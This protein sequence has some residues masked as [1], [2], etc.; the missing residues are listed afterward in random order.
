MPRL[1][2]CDLDGTLLGDDDALRTLLDALH[3]P[4]APVLAF[5][6]GRQGYSAGEMLARAGV[7]NGPYLI[8]GVGTELYRRLG[9][10]WIPVASWPHVEGPW[11]PARIRQML[12]SMPDVRPQ[13]LRSSSAYKLSYFASP[14]AARRV[15]ERL[16]AAGIDATV[17]HSHGDML[18]VLP[19]GIDKGAAVAWLA[20]HLGIALDDVVTCGNT[21]NDL[22][23]LDLE[24]PSVVVGGS[25]D[26]L[27]S[28]APSLPNTYVARERCAAGIME[29]LRAF[30][31][32]SESGW[33]TSS[34][35][36]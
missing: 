7:T 10:H 36:L 16:E 25:D 29:G 11:D 31:W 35:C 13:P 20:R 30:G 15:R 4:D 9:K 6:S 1:L 21:G 5:A 27:L 24:C 12:V 32:L 2:V 22:A 33:H 17:V 26:D 8:A 14:Q 18:D 23:M 34:R 19:V 28:R 3:G